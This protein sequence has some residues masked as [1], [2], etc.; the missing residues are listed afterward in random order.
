MTFF[1]DETFHSSFV[2]KCV[3]ISL[4]QVGKDV[5]PHLDISEHVNTAFTTFSSIFFP[6]LQHYCLTSPVAAKRAPSPGRCTAL[7][8]PLS[9]IYLFI[10]FERLAR[11]SM[12][13]FHPLHASLISFRTAPQRQS[14]LSSRIQNIAALPWLASHE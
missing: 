6:S 13:F 9:T 7:S 5:A 8:L 11:N 3:S 4:L 12:I 14:P 2:F 1:P 10:Y